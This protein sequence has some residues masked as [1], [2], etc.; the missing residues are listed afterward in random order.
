MKVR[1]TT[2]CYFLLAG[3]DGSINTNRL[4][5]HEAITWLGA[6]K[7]FVSVQPVDGVTDSY[8]YFVVRIVDGEKLN[9]KSDHY[10]GTYE[11]ALEEG[12][13]HTILRFGIANTSDMRKILYKVAAVAHLEEQ[14]RVGCTYGDTDM[15]SVAVCYGYN[16]ALANIKD[17]ISDLEWLKD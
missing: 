13:L 6:R 15:D 7:C 1:A 11:E 12:I 14:G 4:E 8:F 5:Q 3:Y 2:H 17:A 10:Y 9:T 16:L